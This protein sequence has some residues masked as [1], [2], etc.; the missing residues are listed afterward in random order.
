MDSSRLSQL[1]SSVVGAAIVDSDF[2]AGPLAALSSAMP[3][4]RVETRKPSGV[5]RRHSQKVIVASDEQRTNGATPMAQQ[6]GGEL[7]FTCRR[8]AVAYFALQGCAVMAWWAVVLYWPRS[9]VL[10]FPGGA[11]PKFVQ[12]FFL[13]DFFLIG[14]GS[15]AAA[16]LVARRHAMAFTLAWGVTACLGYATLLCISWTILDASAHLGSALMSVATLSSAHASI[17]TTRSPFGIF[18]PYR[19]SPTSA[20]VHSVFQVALFWGV[21]LVLLPVW[22]VETQVQLDLDLFRFPAQW[23]VAGC[24][25][26]VFGCLGLWSMVA[27]V[28]V[29]QGTPLPMQGTRRLVV[30]GPYAVVRNP[31]AVAGIGQGIM[32][33]VGWGSVVVIVYAISGCRRMERGAATSGGSIL[34]DRVWR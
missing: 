29:G 11:Q 18:R 16:L 22:L 24:G 7:E 33:G 31:M 25:I 21:F 6:C 28:R 12:S 23:V 14:V 9:Q 3:D 26:G 8:I 32:V 13:P 27:M 1:E 4:A 34:G 2:S 17:L 15:L 20:G 19:G 30:V 10:F 5:H